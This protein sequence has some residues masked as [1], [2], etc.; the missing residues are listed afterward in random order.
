MAIEKWLGITSVALFAMFAGEMIS[1]YNFM[2]DVPE[3]FEFAQAFEADP[4]ILQFISIGVGPAGILAAVAYIMSKQYGS[5]QIGGMIVA[6]GIILLVGMFVC[7]SM[8]DKIDDSY[9]TD[10]VRY[11]LILFMVL[12]APVIGVGLYLTKLKK[13]RPKKEYF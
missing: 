13:K 6:G 12:S 2:I 1:I 7:Y 3:N 5:K 11:V 8:L 9:L 4:K 10:A